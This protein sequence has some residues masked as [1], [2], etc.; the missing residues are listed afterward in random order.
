MANEAVVVELGLRPALSFTV[1]N[2]TGISK[3]AILK[4]TDPRT[5]AASSA[6]GDAFAGIASADKEASDGT[7]KLGVWTQGIFD[8]QC[9]GA[10]FVAG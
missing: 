9:N 3:G 10:G 8:L 6:A 4:I 5:A 1:A 2:G 7:V